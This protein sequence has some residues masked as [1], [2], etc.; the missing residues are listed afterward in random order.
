MN[1]SQS[2]FAADPSADRSL[3][4]IALSRTR[5]RIALRLHAT[6]YAIVNSGLVT[7]WLFSPAQR[8][9]PG[10]VMAGWGIGLAIQALARQQF[11]RGSS[12]WM[13]IHAEELSRARSEARH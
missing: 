8:F 5:S 6:V 11:A 9:W 1:H 4:A 13:R 3:E 10:F 7:I 2:T 12:T